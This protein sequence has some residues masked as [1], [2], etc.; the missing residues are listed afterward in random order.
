[1]LARSDCALRPSLPSCCIIM[2]AAERKERM[3]ETAVQIKVI[4]GCVNAVLIHATLLAT[5]M[6]TAGYKWREAMEECNG[7]LLPSSFSFQLSVLPQPPPTPFLSLSPSLKQLDSDTSC[8]ELE[9][10][11]VCLVKLGIT[12][13]SGLFIL[14]K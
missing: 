13:T 5:F 7:T 8:I 10:C 12:L 4:K 14:P 9:K 2:L 11:H 6:K 3:R 1:M